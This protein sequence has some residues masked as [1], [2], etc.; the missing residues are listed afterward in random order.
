MNI[1]QLTGIGRLPDPNYATNLAIIIISLLV[2]SIGGLVQL[3][4]GSELA[5]SAIWGFEA[6]LGAFFAW[7]LSREIDP[8]HELSAFVSTGLFI[9]SLVFVNS[10]AILALL[11]ALIGLRILNC[12]TGV[13]AKITDGLI[14]LALGAWVSYHNSAIYIFITTVIFLLDALL[15]PPNRK[16]LVLTGLSIVI[17]VVLW[18]GS[19]TTKWNF[20]ISPINL[21]VLLGIELLFILTIM[22]SSEVSAQTDVTGEPLDLTR[23]RIAQGIALLIPILLAIFEGFEGIVSLLPLWSTFLGVS[24]YRLFIMVNIVPSRHSP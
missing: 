4:N 10:S 3:I 12:I 5:V 6:G 24:L 1:H 19:W 22:L 14:F 11:W 23:V 20:E 13:P 9:I 21:G 17:S 16:Q 8:E 7:A 15:N 18:I 2:G